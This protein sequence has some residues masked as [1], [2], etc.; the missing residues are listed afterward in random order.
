MAACQHTIGFVSHN[1]ESVRLRKHVVQVVINAGDMLH[2][3]R[4]AMAPGKAAAADAV[5]RLMDELSLPTYATGK[6]TS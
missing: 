4:Q 5:N 6:H 2:V 3:Y 1:T